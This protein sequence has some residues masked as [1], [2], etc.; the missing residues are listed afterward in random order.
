[1]AGTRPPA[2]WD[3]V[4]ALADRTDHR[5]SRRV[6]LDLVG[7]AAA[8]QA[9]GDPLERRRHAGLAAWDALAVYRLAGGTPD[10]LA[11]F[12]AL[13]AAVDRPDDATGP[14]GDRARLARAR[15]ELALRFV[16]DDDADEHAAHVADVEQRAAALE[17]P[18]THGQQQHTP[19]HADADA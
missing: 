9:A 8:L 1:M 15:V 7:A 14:L 12:I 4:V 11:R 13:R 6:S 17:R 3:D 18:R 10:H 19:H 16:V 5:S 2:S